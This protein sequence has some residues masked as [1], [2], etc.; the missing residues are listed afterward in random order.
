MSSRDAAPWP[1]SLNGI[2]SA[3]SDGETLSSGTMTMPCSDRMIKRL[4]TDSV[5]HVFM[6]SVIREELR[7]SALVATVS[8]FS[9]ADTLAFVVW[10]ESNRQ[11]TES[12]RRK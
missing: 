12:R 8:L 5:N 10:H 2:L 9:D 6:E 11:E 4:S 3:V 1:A 7:R